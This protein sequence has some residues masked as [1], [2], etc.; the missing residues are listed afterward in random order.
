MKPIIASTR[1]VRINNILVSENW[2]AVHYWDVTTLDD[3]TKDV[4]NHMQFLRFAED[5]DGVKVDL[6]WAC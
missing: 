3:G 4:A 1:R 6:C 2:T 5:G